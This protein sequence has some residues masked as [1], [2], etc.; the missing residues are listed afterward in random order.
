MDIKELLQSLPPPDPTAP[1]RVWH[2]AQDTREQL[3]RQ[4]W[5]FPIGL[6]V[7]TAVLASIGMLP[8]TSEREVTLMS[9]ASDGPRAMTWS[10]D[11]EFAFEGRGSVQ[12]PPD[13][14][15][16]D[17]QDGTFRAEVVPGS[18]T[19][20]EVRTAEASVTV[21]GTVFE[22]HRD[23]LGTVT[24]VSKG[25]VQVVC[26]DGWEGPVNPTT[27]PHTCLPM[28]PA[29]LLG[30]A[31][32]LQQ[33][34]HRTGQVLEALAS[35]LDRSGDAS[36]V[37]GELL[38]FRMEVLADAGRYAEAISD[39]DAYVEGQGPRSTE[40]TRF[41]GWLAL[42]DQGCEQAMPYL[43]ELGDDATDQDRIL[44]SEC[45]VADNP[46]RA[47]RWMETVRFESLEDAWLSRAQT[48]MGR[49]NGGTQ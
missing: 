20:L 9:D 22:V 2:R 12:G 15:V 39:A 21:T 4:W 42:S 49:L 27:G 26:A 35:G 29:M 6:L 19:G 24:S 23:A 16:I 41:A 44:L 5:L 3:R 28:Q 38:A 47:R 11:V 40:V 7:A 14:I 31:M 36:A 13:D 30:R 46:D 17:W 33:R 43:E 34:G 32:L 25:E 48:V 8:E 1:K 45:L 18:G 10:D 37:R